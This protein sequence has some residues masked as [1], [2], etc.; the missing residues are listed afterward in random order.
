MT[1]I[2]VGQQRI[3]TSYRIKSLSIQ[4][5][6]ELKRRPVIVT[7]GFRFDK[8][9]NKFVDQNEQNTIPVEFRNNSALNKESKTEDRP[10]DKC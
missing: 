8:A 2:Y 3:L 10:S 6:L 9:A 5:Y 4:L 1:L 7:N